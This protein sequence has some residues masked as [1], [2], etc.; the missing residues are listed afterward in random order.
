MRRWTLL[1]AGAALWLFLAAIPALADGGPHVASVNSGSSTLTADGCAGCHRAHTAQG[2]MLLNAA[3][4]EALCL[5]LPRRDRHRRHDRR[6]DAA[7]STLAATSAASGRPD[8]RSSARSAT[9]AST[10]PR[11]NAH[12][13]MRLTYIRN[14]IG[15]ISTR[16]K[17]G[18]LAAPE[19]V[20][21]AHMDI[22]NNST[23]SLA[24]WGIAWGN[25]ASGTSPSVTLGCASCHNPHGNG[26]YRILNPVP[27]G[28]NVTQGSAVSI[29][30]TA[31][32]DDFTT[33]ANHDFIVGSRVTISGN[34]NTAATYWDEA[35]D[36]PVLVTGGT[37]NGT[38]TVASVS[39]TT[40]TANV[41]VFRLA[42]VDVTI[43]QATATGTVTREADV[44]VT[45]SPMGTPTAGGVYPTKNYTVTQVKGTP[46][47]DASFML[48]A[49]DVANAQARHRHV[50][51][52]HLHGDERRLPAPHRPVEPDPHQRG[53]QP[54]AEPVKHGQPCHRGKRDGLRDDQRCPQRESR[55]VQRVDPGHHAAR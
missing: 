17:V 18:V 20:K 29:A 1:L 23:D 19:P 13:P 34:T 45:D 43:G 39:T 10:R 31:T 49:S 28:S 14:N 51:G 5:S 47:T 53:L 48:F 16:P 50:A 36:P 21:S 15:D 24:P 27:N 7:S 9:A 2:A 33:S 26:Q 4:E 44:K 30:S 52:G 22:H 6:R 38:F 55:H 3:D 12:D 8:D 54:P 42:G 40:G 25:G 41:R 46:G 11:I 37:I 35:A 32:N